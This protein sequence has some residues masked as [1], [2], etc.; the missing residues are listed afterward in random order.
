MPLRN[1]QEAEM[2]RAR[3]DWPVTARISGAVSAVQFGQQ[4]A[5]VEGH[6]LSG[7]VK[8]E[9]VSRAG[10]ACATLSLGFLQD[11]VGRCQASSGV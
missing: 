7:D 2:A 3:T 8:E 5:L 10:S 4:G 1:G 9:A 11:N 6:W